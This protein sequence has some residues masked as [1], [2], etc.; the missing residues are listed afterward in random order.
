MLTKEGVAYDHEA[1]DTYSVTVRVGDGQG[2]RATVVVGITVTD[3]DEPPGGPPAGVAVTPR[4][5]ALTVT[6]NAAP[7]EAGKPPVSGYEVAHRRG[8]A[9]DWQEG[10]MLN[11]RTDTSVTLTRLTNEQPYQVRARTLNHEGASEWSE[12]IA[13]APTVGPQRAL[14]IR[15]QSLY[16]GGGNG[17]VNLAIAFTRPG[18]RPLSYAAAS[19]AATTSNAAGQQ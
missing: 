16:T 2:G 7:D 17:R 3:V 10:M 5:T 18:G 8:D 9:G 13:R 12:P 4:D 15:D 14:G 1:R 19:T 11:S 6:W